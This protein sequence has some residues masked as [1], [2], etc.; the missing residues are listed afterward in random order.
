MN[1]FAKLSQGIPFRVLLLTVLT[2]GSAAVSAESSWLEVQLVQ[3][4]D[5][6]PLADAAVC[7]GTSARLDQFGARRTDS[8]GVVRFDDIRHH[9]LV[10]TASR[11]GYQGREQRLE[12]IYQNRVLVV[13]MVTGGGGPVC[14]APL[15]RSSDTEA[16][17]L[18]IDA[19]RIRKDVNA[20]AAGVLVS[21]RVSGQVNQIRISETADFKGA[22]WQHY[23]AAVPFDLSS[24]KGLKR[25]YVQVRRA[26]EVQ[27]ASIEVQ[28]SVR[29]VDYRVN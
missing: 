11:R 23:E 15:S 17:S 2:A 14:D 1:T 27:G 8:R 16:S 20:G 10:V 13:K 26:S 19:V 4:Q 29:K 9:P 28:S 12:P 3:K 22:A 7:L 24:G 18:T 25:L 6:T 21:A 5:G